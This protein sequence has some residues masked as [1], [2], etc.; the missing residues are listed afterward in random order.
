MKMTGCQVALQ[1]I[2]MAT[3]FIGVILNLLL[4]PKFGID[5]A[6]YATLSSISFYNVLLSIYIK[7]NFG[8]YSFYLPF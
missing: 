8:I 6:A 7:K 2:T 3:V 4:I 5:G 1:N